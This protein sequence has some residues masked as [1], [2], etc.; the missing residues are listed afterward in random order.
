MKYI[1]STSIVSQSTCNLTNYYA[2]LA[3][4]T[5]THNYL[6]TRAIEHCTNIQQVFGTN[7]KVTTDNII[8]PNE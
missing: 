5:A 1:N 2:A 7:I 3:D 8:S 4:T 6:E